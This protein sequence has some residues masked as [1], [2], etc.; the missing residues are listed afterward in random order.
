MAIPEQ[1][2]RDSLWGTRKEREA[3][4]RWQ[5]MSTEPT[6]VMAESKEELSRNG[7]RRASAK[8]TQRPIQAEKRQSTPQS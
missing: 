2:T 3:G 1:G 8:V 5:K 7:T 4:K 6:G